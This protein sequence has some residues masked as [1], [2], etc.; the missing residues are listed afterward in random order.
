MSHSFH[1]L[2][3]FSKGEAYQSLLPQIKALIVGETDTIANFVNIS[4]ALKMIFGLFWVGFYI[5]KRGGLVLGPFQR[6]IAC[7]RIK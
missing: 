2:S 7:T 5:L 3:I 1:I 6:T 4:A